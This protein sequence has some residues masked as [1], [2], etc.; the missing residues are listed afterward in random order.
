MIRF[1]TSEDGLA[2]AKLVLVILKDMEL[3]FVKEIGEAK[4]IEILTEAVKDPTYRYGYKRGLVKEVAGE[5]AGIAFGYPAEEEAIVDDALALV[6][7]E[8]GMTDRPLFLDPETFPNEWYLDTICVDEAFRGQGIGSELLDALDKMA[9]R[10]A[11]S[12]IGLCVDQAN[13]NA[14]RLYERKG[15]AVV[16]EQMLSGHKYN[17]MQKNI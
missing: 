17:H 15:F 2:I 6:L 1:A 4:T 12:V 7:K 11:K 3:P 9:K 14:Q 10:E 8:M 13:P 5:I 16:G